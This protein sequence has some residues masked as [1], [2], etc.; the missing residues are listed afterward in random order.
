MKKIVLFIGYFA[1]V[2]AVL[3]APK[4]VVILLGDGMGLNHLYL[5]ELL[6]G[7]NPPTRLFST[8][9]GLNVPADALITDSAAAATALFS[10]HRTVNHA[11]GLDE[12]GNP[13]ELISTTL[14]KHGWNVG[15]IT[16]ARYSDG[17][18][19]GFYA[20]AFRTDTAQITEDLLASDLD[21]FVAGGLEKLGLNLFTG[22][23]KKN[24]A[25]EA[26]SGEGYDVHGFNFERLFQAKGEKKGTMIFVAAGDNSFENELLSNEMSLPDIVR[27]SLQFLDRDE[28]NF[29][30]V[31][32]ARID[33]ACHVNDEE[34]VKAELLAFQR[35]L[36]VLLEEFDPADTL[37]L[38]LA[39]HETGG[40]AIIMGDQA[41]VNLE[42]GWC[43]S[44]HTASYIPLLSYGQGRESFDGFLHLSDVYYEL[45]DLLG[46]N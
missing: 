43:S 24:S 17:T 41:A 39:D 40:L 18:P 25:L 29:L 21:L 33:D 36:A 3:A 14:K 37:F 28:R 44:D 11:A 4:N 22:R 27:E 13:V 32:A 10:G 7:E 1:I 26:L 20:H 42:L 45:L 19:A 6:Y 30:V 16:N 9:L 12:T 38:I 2:L 23:V 46:V 5:S 31:E 34:A 8:A 35:T 15:M